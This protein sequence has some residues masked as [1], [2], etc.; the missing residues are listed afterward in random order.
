MLTILVAQSWKLVTDHRPDGDGLVAYGFLS[1]LARRGHRLHVVCRGVDLRVPP[2]PGLHLLSVD[3]GDEV[4]GGRRRLRYMRALRRALARLSAQ[5][6][7]DVVHQPNPVDV[8][9]TL[10]LPRSA[11][12][13]VLGPY[14][15]S[16]PSDVGSAGGEAAR[17]LLRA[18]QQ[19][20]AAAVLLASEAARAK[21]HVRGVP[22]AVVPPG[23]D[24]ERFPVVGGREP[25]RP[26]TALFFAN[27]RAHKGVFTLLDAWERVALALPG[28]R[29]LVAGGGPEAGRVAERVAASPAGT[30]IELLGPVQREGIAALMARAD[31]FCHPAHGE[32]FGTSAVEAMA[33]GLPVVAT[34]AGGL[35]HVVPDDAGLKVPPADA[36]ALAAALVALLGD[37]ER[38]AAMAAA[39][40][41]H[42]EREFAWERVIDRLEAAL[43]DAA[44]QG[45]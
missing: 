20:R 30:T 33:S 3:G 34:A 24:L 36:P 38:R 8:G 4:L 40:R 18:A 39:G 11:P 1:R 29:L 44:R 22:T 13:V 25:G 17:A 32:P 5:E 31:V 12:P 28:A 26:P 19:R 27:L 15:P 35:A 10:A 41:R 43:G 42:V 6:A 2:P 16:W 14:W 9:V 23:I 21:V 37:P 45:R 7:L